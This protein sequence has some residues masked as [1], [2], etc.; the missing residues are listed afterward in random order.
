M[1]SGKT[2][3][4]RR[5]AERLGWRFVD[6]DEAIVAMAGQDI[7]ALF[8]Q[9]EDVFR[10]W[11][12]QAIAAHAHDE[13]TVIA[14]GGGA[15]TQ[16]DTRGLLVALGPVVC[17]TAPP[18]VLW[19]RA[20]ADPNRP[21]GQDREAFLARLAA[22]QAIYD[23]PAPTR[24]PRRSRPA[25]PA[26]TSTWRWASGPTPSTSPRAACGGCPSRCPATPAAA[27]W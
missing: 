11:E 7:P 13:E 20:G 12:R 9:G 16:A 27:W 22:R 23:R 21:L 2:T 5:L 25:W 4:G 15:V 6:V 24:W 18:D 26:P 10:H 8:A 14:T 3:V 1:G 17:L 19:Q